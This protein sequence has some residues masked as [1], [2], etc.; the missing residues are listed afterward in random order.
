MGARGQN[1]A[2]PKLLEFSLFI[3]GVRFASILFRVFCEKRMLNI[4]LLDMEP[5]S[6]TGGV[7]FI[8]KWNAALLLKAL[9]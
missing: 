7:A 6:Q 9:E 8:I 3:R 4:A 5:V 1:R 2:R